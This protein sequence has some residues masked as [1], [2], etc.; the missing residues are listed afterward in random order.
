MSLIDPRSG[1]PYPFGAKLPSADVNAVWAQQ[2]RALDAVDGGAYTLGQDLDW[3]LQA[4][5]KI[6]DGSTGKVEWGENLYPALKPR[7][8]AFLQ[9]L[10]F[11]NSDGG[12]GLVSS[13]S[14][15]F[16]A[17]TNVSGIAKAMFALSR[18]PGI[19][20]NAGTLQRVRVYFSLRTSVGQST[21]PTFMPAVELYRTD[22]FSAAPAL[23]GSATDTASPFSVYAASHAVE[24]D[25]TGGGG[26][27][28]GL[29]G[30][31]LVV[32]GQ[33]G[34]GATA[35]ALYIRRIEAHVEMTQVRP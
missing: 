18:I 20:G 35:D 1:L 27:A 9:P 31:T 32:S 19:Q 30:L 33:S 29:Q 23:V 14:Y 3:L 13:T 2:P 10:T 34:G 22:F 7:T 26:L 5:I 15:A 6:A 11:T 12:W 17:N 21:L 25:L 8:V 16:P 28:L 24:I 4:D